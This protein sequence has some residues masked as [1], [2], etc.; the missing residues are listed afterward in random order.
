[1]AIHPLNVSAGWALILAAFV[2]GA[3]I[4]LG[5]HKPGFLGGYD[6]LRRR[7]LRLGHIAFAAIGMINI[8]FGLTPY[9]PQGSVAGAVASYGLFAGGLAMPA[10]CFLTAWREPMRHL[11]AIPVV[12]LVSA[13]VA[14]LI[15]G[16]VS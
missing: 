11:F 3:L 4:G 5:F 1:M 16:I 12:C 9:P 6:S 7:M 14:I 15:G 10:V 2:S 8:L 13:V